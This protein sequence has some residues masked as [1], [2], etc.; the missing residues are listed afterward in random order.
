MI[1]HMMTLSKLIVY[2]KTLQEE[3]T[4]LSPKLLSSKLLSSE[5]FFSV[6]DHGSE[7]NL[8]DPRQCEKKYSDFFP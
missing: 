1:L 8:S 7:T 3:I 6:L 5:N 2:K 4:L